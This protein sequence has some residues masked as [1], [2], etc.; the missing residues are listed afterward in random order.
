MYKEDPQLA[1]MFASFVPSGFTGSQFPWQQVQW[2]PV[3]YTES[4]ENAA[5]REGVQ[6]PEAKTATNNTA[7]NAAHKDKQGSAE[8][9]LRVP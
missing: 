5:R 2:M 3:N 4:A 7:D 8:K 1:A 9:R 6:L